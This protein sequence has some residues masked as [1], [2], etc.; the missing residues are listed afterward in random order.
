MSSRIPRSGCSGPLARRTWIRHVPTSRSCSIGPSNW[1]P[2]NRSSPSC[3]VR[4]Q[5]SSAATY[6]SKETST[7]RQNESE[8]IAGIMLVVMLSTPPPH[9]A[10]VSLLSPGNLVWFPTLSRFVVRLLPLHRTNALSPVSPDGLDTVNPQGADLNR[11]SPGQNLKDFVL[12]SGCGQA[13][14]DQPTATKGRL[15]LYTRPIRTS[16]SR[17]RPSVA[18][19]ATLV[20]S[21]GLIAAPARRGEGCASWRWRCLVLPSGRLRAGRGGQR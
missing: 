3:L 7:I 17:A 21:Q 10:H 11:L 6:V 15:G 9:G 8:L 20:R 4:S 13:A 16:A 18:V 19:S 14:C 12:R 1:L 2:P 5:L